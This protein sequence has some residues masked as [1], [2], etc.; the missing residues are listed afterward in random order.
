[1]ENA[2][3]TNIETKMV[4]D[5][6]TITQKDV[7]DLFCPLATEKEV[8]MALGIVKSLN[9][10]PFI[11]ECYFIKYSNTDKMQI[12]VGYEVYLK[13]AERTGLLNGWKAGIKKD[14]GV[15]WVEISRKDWTEPF[16]WEVNLNEF[17]KKQSTWKTIPSFMA[18][19]VAIAQG[20]RLC[21]PTEL[22]GLPYTKDEIDSYGINNNK[23]VKPTV[24]PPKEI[25]NK[26][27]PKNEDKK[28]EIIT[29]EETL[30]QEEI[31]DVEDDIVL[32]AEKSKANKELDLKALAQCQDLSELKNIWVAIQKDY[33]T[34]YLPSDW[35]EIVSRKE[36]FKKI[37]QNREK[38]ERGMKS[39]Q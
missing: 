33:Q 27:I 1:M 22:A 24:E 14:D 37:L 35:S 2:Q 10:N 36:F 17:D 25:E 26:S 4:S 9:L 7:K 32:T 3:L 12:V 16:Y 23:P 13:R 20:F 34:K 21:F 30:S 15:A 19:K 28:P 5:T 31:I 38:S 39:E 8:A 29:Q 18:K 6:I 11:H